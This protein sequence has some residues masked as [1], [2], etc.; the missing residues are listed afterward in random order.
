MHAAVGGAVREYVYGMGSRRV[1][2]VDGG[3]NLVGAET[4]F[5]ERYLGTETPS[6]FVWAFSLRPIHALFE[7]DSFPRPRRR[8]LRAPRRGRSV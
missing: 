1:T 4:S 8:E 5:G 3:Q 2:V 7:W 6:G